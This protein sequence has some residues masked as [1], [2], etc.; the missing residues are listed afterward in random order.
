[1][2]IRRSMLFIPG[3][4]PGMI[5]TGGLFGADVVILDLED[6]VSL[7]EKDAA[8]ILAAQALKTVNYGKAEVAVRINSLDT[9]AKQD[10]EVIIPCKPD[11]VILPKVNCAADIKDLAAMIG[12]VEREGQNQI[13]ILA[14]IEGPQGVA[15]AYGIAKSHPRLAG[16]IF[17]AEDYTA[18]VESQRTKAGNEIFVARSLIVNA[19]AAAGIQRFDAVFTD[20]NDE[21]GLV[22][23]TLLSKQLGFTGKPAISPRHIHVINKIFNPS[24]EE[25]E[26]A[27]QIIQAIREAER[28]GSGV[29][30]LNGR[31]VD[32]PVVN[33]AKHV[34]HLAQLLGL[35][36]EEAE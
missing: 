36:K 28:E 16:L 17:G 12:E 4:N 35:V 10:L 9:F 18:G 11:L 7:N 15:E 22:Q 13:R 2:N 8:R 29:I 20:V 27:R 6:T 31:M 30:S 23:D 5:Q 33:R 32:A 19:A 21:E 34:M 14:I 24:P 25:I 1:M 3:N 26:K